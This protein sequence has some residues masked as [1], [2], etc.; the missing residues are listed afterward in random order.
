MKDVLIVSILFI[1]IGI[2]GKVYFYLKED[3]TF[4]KVNDFWKPVKRK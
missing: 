3:D 4:V 2:I 1:I